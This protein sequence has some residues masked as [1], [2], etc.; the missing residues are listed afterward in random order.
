MTTLPPSFE[1]PT[2]RNNGRDGAARSRKKYDMAGLARRLLK[3][4]ARA[5]ALTAVVAVAAGAAPKPPA[6][7]NVLRATLPNGLRVIL[8]RNT[9]APVVATAV[10]YLV[11]SDEAPKGFPGTAHAQEHMMFRG[12]PGLDGDQLAEIGSLMGGNFNA[13]TRESITQYLFTVPAEDLDLALH[14]EAVRMA[15]VSDSQKD[16]DT[17]RGAIEQEVA[18]DLSNPDYALYEKLRTIMFAGSQYEHDALGTRPSFDRTTA[19]MLKSFHDAWY[20][21]NNAILIVVGDLDPQATLTKIKTL[22]GPLKPKTLPAR[23]KLKLTPQKAAAFTL[24]TDQPNGTLVLAMR[25]PGMDSADFPALEVLADVLSNHRFALYGLVPQGKAIDANFSLAP[26]PQSGIAYAQVVFPDG[27]DP[28]KI[29][30]D[31]RAILTK[32]KKD[33]VSPDLVKAAITEEQRET[34]FEKNSIPDLASIW[35]DAVALYHLPS[36]DADLA[37]IEKVTAADVN[38]VARKYLDLDQA[39]SAVLLPQGSGKPVATSAGFGGQEHI[40]LGEAKGVPLPPWAGAAEVN[41][42]VPPSTL[43]PTVTTLPNGITLIVQPETVSNTVTISGHIVNRPE[44]EAAPGKEGVALVLDDLFPFGTEEHD[45]LAYQTALDEIGASEKAGPD[46]EIQALSK[47][48]DRAA[49]L[50]AE[51][52]LHPA[53]PQPAFDIVKGQTTQYIASRN[54]SPGYLAERALRESLFPQDDPSLRDATPATLQPLTLADVRDY[55]NT[56]YRPDMTSIVVI[57]NVTPDQAK[58]VIEKYFGSWAATGPKPNVDLPVQPPNQATAV[59]VPDASRVQDEVY[60]SQNLGLNRAD[61]D[62][63]AL[64]LGNAVLAGGFYSARLSI[65]L[66]KN[67]G[68]VYSVGAQLEIRRTRGVYYVEY[69]CDPQNVSKAADIVSRDFKG[70]QDNPVGADELTRAKTLLLR[71][72]P[73]DESSVDEIARGILNR[74]DLNLPIDEPTIAAQRY[75]ALTPAE[76]QAAFQKWVRPPGLVRIS[77]G[78]AP[79]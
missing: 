79:Q 64:A 34:E 1:Q 12:N 56:V 42:A 18:Q 66:R 26:L 13:N 38:R 29:E 22:F 33:G 24:Q 10:N 7:A 77:R 11:G 16:W 67:A 19:A 21:P 6:D 59:A 78:P 76:V 5:F 41:L 68:L 47:Y 46:F 43:H 40:A 8:V 69:A 72:I 57:G 70:M 3:V 31:V 61:P 75:V 28:K 55:Y 25:M 2:T 53:L 48:F 9:L 60:L 73:L 52:E 50:L 35:S 32:F 54:K 63:Y 45:R 74:R 14:V 17:E 49:A 20:A 39:V 37:R 58:E 27:T 62:Y 36:P 65:D 23:P 71:Q 30:S 15:G 4:A 44:T 51:N